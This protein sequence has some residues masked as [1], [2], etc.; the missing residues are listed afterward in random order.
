MERDVALGNECTMK[1]ADDVLVSCTL[2]TCMVLQ[3]NVTPKIQL[4]LFCSGVPIQ[5][6]HKINVLC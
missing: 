1:C 6:R 2:E 3:T 4:K 5:N